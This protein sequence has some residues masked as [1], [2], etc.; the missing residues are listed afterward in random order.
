MLCG[1]GKC[2]IPPK[3]GILDGQFEKNFSNEFV[4]SKKLAAA[5]QLFASK[6]GAEPTIVHL[7]LYEKVFLFYIYF[8]L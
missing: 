7:F 8:V 3:E 6:I 4:Q 1:E 5:L 2:C